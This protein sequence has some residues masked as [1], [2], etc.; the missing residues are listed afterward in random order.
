MRVWRL[1]AKIHAAT[2]FS[3]IGNKNAGSRWVPEGE[4]AV[5]TSEHVSTAVLENLVHMDP[6]HFRND[7]VLIAGDIPD[8]LTMDVVS[9]EN[10]APDWQIRYEDE[11]LQQIG[12]DWIHRGE[13]VILIVPSAVFP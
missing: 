13:S 9:V 2:A 3:G 7:S 10:L 12:K 6:S 4:L 5:Y 11:A 8:E 1:I